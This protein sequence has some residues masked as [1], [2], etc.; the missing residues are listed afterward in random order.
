[1]KFCQFVASVYPHMLT[2]SGRFILSFNKMVLIFLGVLIF[3]PFQVSSF[4][5]SDCLYFIAN[6]E[7]PQFTQPQSTGLSGLGAMLES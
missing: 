3:S 2:N 7:W 5:K 6:D 4:N 1:M